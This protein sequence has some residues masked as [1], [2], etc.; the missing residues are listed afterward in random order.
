MGGVGGKEK[1]SKQQKQM[2]RKSCPSIF[3]YLCAF[4]TIVYKG[5]VCTIFLG[6]LNFFL[7]K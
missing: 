7:L 5:T 3:N 1:K 2:P 6:F 4:M